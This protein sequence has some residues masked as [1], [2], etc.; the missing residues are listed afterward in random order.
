MIANF[1][2]FS[3]MFIVYMLFNAVFFHVI[4][5]YIRGMS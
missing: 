5:N 1:I 3:F 4:A 2:F